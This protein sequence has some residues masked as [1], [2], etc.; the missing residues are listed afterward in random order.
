MNPKEKFPV[1]V[2]FVKDEIDN[3]YTAFFA[4][5]PNIISEG[6]DENEATDNLFKLVKEVFEHQKNEEIKLAKNQHMSNPSSVNTRSF[7]LSI[8]V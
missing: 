7:D 6:K 4:Q 3:G 2:I 1:T 5:F 8:A